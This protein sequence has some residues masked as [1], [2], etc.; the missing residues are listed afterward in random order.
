LKDHEIILKDNGFLVKGMFDFKKY[1]TI[2]N[3]VDTIGLFEVLN[4]FYSSFVKHF[5]IDFTHC[6][7]LPQLVMD[8]F[9]KKFFN[10]DIKVKLFT[11]RFQ[12]LMSKAYYGGITCVY[13]PMGTML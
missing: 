10:D 6:I 9:R 11:K 13:K 1:S 12:N 5:N 4:K 3:Q 7:T 2:Y 8:L